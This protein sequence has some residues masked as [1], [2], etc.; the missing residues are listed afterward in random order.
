M[1]HEHKTQERVKCFTFQS[2]QMK[3]SQS[4]VWNSSLQHLGNVSRNHMS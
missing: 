4:V 1:R 3:L 2:T